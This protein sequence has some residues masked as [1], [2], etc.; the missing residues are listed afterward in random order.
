VLTDPNSYQRWADAELVRASPPEPVREGQVLD[1]RTRKLGVAFRVLMDVGKPEPPAAPAS[2][3]HAV[4][5]RERR[6]HHAGAAR[7]LAGVL[8]L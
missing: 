5:H 1:F 2:S 8:V 4:R 6:A 7:P 3:P